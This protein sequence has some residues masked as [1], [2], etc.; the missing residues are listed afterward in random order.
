MIAAG[1]VLTFA[2]DGSA[3]LGWIDPT[4]TP[5]G[6]RGDVIELMRPYVTVNAVTLTPTSNVYVGIANWSY[7]AIVQVTTKIAHADASDVGSIVAHAFYEAANL[8]PTV[9]QTGEQPANVP[10]GIGQEPD[11]ADNG[12]SAMLAKFFG[13]LQSTVVM[14]AIGAI[15]LGVVLL[16][17]EKP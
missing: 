5:E 17:A 16:K 8:M 3:T 9:T 11:D 6:V 1:T 2:V 14:V 7:R 12:I 4:E 13:G 15:V 10:G